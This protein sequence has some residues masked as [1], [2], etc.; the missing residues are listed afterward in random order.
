MPNH[1]DENFYS[2]TVNVITIFFSTFMAIGLQKI[3]DQPLDGQSRLCFI[4]AL[5]LFL[6]FLAGSANHLWFEH[7]KVTPT[8]ETGK[9]L[10]WHFVW[11]MLFAFFGLQ[12]CYS[13]SV[14]KF[15]LWTAGFAVL[16][17]ALPFVD[18]L[19][20]H[21]RGEKASDWFYKWVKINVAFLIAVGVVYFWY[22]AGGQKNVLYGVNLP[23]GLFALFCLVLLLRDLYV[24]FDYLHHKFGPTELSQQR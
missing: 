5:S 7:V 23:I 4:V 24:Q 19:R 17:V 22:K 12:M 8:K 16:A 1:K 3:L 10:L 21:L 11:L 20:E 14:N 13:D 18:T 6:R 9:D 2:Q 15:L